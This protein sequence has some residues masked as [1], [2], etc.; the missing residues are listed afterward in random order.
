[1]DMYE[2]QYEHIPHF[3]FS[4]GRLGH[5]DLLCPTPGSR[6]ANGNLPFG[7]GMRAPEEGRRA[8][9]SEGST[10]LGSLAQDSNTRQKLA[11]TITRLRLV[12]KLVVVSSTDLP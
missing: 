6:D 8:S 5:S 1:M 12:L 4:C 11:N 9:Y 7:K 2:I 3:C 10:R